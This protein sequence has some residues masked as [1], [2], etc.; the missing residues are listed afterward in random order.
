M[1]QTHTQPRVPLLWYPYPPQSG[2]SYARMPNAWGSVC[3]QRLE[4]ARSRAP[5]T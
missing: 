4:Y 3:S 1:E 5:V 2:K